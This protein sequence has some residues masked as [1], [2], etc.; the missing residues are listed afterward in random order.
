MI[1]GS[2]AVKAFLGR[3]LGV[4]QEPVWSDIQREGLLGFGVEHWRTH[5]RAVP[6][7][8]RLAWIRS[9]AFELRCRQTLEQISKC[10]IPI[11]VFKGCSLASYA[12][13][14]PG[15]RSFG[16]IDLAAAPEHWPI[17]RKN[18]GLMGFRE[19]S[20][21]QFSNQGLAIDLHSHPLHQLTGLVGPK[22]KEW[23]ALARPLW[24]EFPSLLRLTLEHEF[25]LTLFHASKH[26]F[27]RA[28]WV[29]DAALLAQIGEPDRL[30]DAVRH[31]KVRRQ[32]AYTQYCLQSWFDWRFPEPLQE[33]RFPRLMKWEKS[34]LKLVLERRAPDYLGMLTPLSSAHNLQAALGYL[35]RTLY[36]DKT[37]LLQRTK[38]LLGMARTWK[39]LH[40]G[41]QKT[42][43]PS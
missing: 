20:P 6:D 27:S 17:L 9:V 25:V 15:L 29:I 22:S 8:V 10:E 42:P 2:A 28:G 39:G 1:P 12:Y 21:A 4:E 7:D 37:Q 11:I 13:P 30:A 34:F 40:S 24:P 3:D 33:S 31:F 14:R 19:Y 36:P 43:S 26:A 5:G 41:S 18:L 35:V 38:Q 32:L 16:D 23:W